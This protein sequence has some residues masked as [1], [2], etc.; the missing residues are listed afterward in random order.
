MKET[1]IALLKT[2][3]SGDDTITPEHM[4][5]ILKACQKPAPR[6]K[7]ISARQ[8]MEILDIS[9]PTLREYVKRGAL[10]QINLSLRKV[11]FDA[12]EVNRLAYLGTQPR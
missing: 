6:R 7:L 9:R 3:L 11:R 8:A 2:V 10:S 5:A 12:E 1:T 4:D